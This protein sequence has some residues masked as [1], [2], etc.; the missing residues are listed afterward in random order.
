MTQNELKEKFN[1]MLDDTHTHTCV[2]GLY[3]CPSSVLYHLDYQMYASA[4]REYAEFLGVQ[5]EGEE[6]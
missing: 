5:V 2:M 3:F 1:K 6:T 4:M